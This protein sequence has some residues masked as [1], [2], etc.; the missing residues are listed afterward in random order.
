MADSMRPV[1]TRWIEKLRLARE[2]KKKEF[3][4]D[5]DEA[6]RFFDGPYDWLYKGWR[7]GG[8]GG[9]LAMGVGD[10]DVPGPSVEM[11]V[12]K[13]AE[14]VQLF[15]PA[16]YHQNPY[17][18]VSPRKPPTLPAELY[19]DPND[20]NLQAY[21]QQLGARQMQA[22]AADRSRAMLLEH[23]L[24]YT[25]DALDLKTQSRWAIDEALIKGMGVLWTMP[26][27][28][29][30][31]GKLAGSFFG[32]VDD[33]FMDPDAET[34]GEAKWVARRCR[35]PIWEVEQ[36]YGLPPGTLRNRGSMESYTQAANISASDGGDGDY[37]RKKGESCDLITY[38]KIWSKMGLGGRLSG[39]PIDAADRY[40]G[41]GN[42]VYLVVCDGCTYPLNVPRDLCDFLC[43]EDQS[44]RA[45]AAQAAGQFVQWETPYW[46][47]DAWPFEPIAF[48]WRPRKLWPMS[49]MKPAMGFL[50]F[51]NWTYSMMA[52][53]IRIACRD[54]IAVAKSAGEELKNSI[55]HGA[56]FTI[57][58]VESIHGSIDQVVKFLSH[59]GFNPEIYKVLEGAIAAFERA[60]GLSELMY[61]L[62][63]RQMRSA[64]E[65][66][67]KSDAINVRPDDMATKVEEAMTNLSRREAFCLRWHLS[68]QQLVGV[69]GTDGAQA[70]DQL[71]T[72]SDPAT[73][74]R[75]LEYRIE[76][77]SIR[78]PNR[79]T[80]AENMRQAT[81]SLSQFFFQYAQATGD[82]APFNALVTDWAKSIDLDAAGYQLQPPPPPPPPG[83]GPPPGPP[84]K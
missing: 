42:F 15:G 79:A 9:A 71:L 81:Q 64:Q 65:A 23:V 74:L 19:G 4:D 53:K 44:V 66:S 41:L 68:G 13:T 50:Q 61:G 30:A 31:G 6:N 54:F 45:Q 58:D 28:P 55:K 48:H 11:T 70:W 67:V 73:I 77:N 33:L 69:L 76:A 7:K 27:N 49:H 72:V 36:Q 38:Y 29:A 10:E 37:L 40:D 39:M 35:H 18:K 80:E 34:I 14:L 1:V 26:T 56:D 22:G 24:N 63:N 5:A 16:L 2:H 59:P 78:K 43:D 3:Q 8:P 57:I 82:V 83:Q 60:T 21:L 47:D 17:R 32:T 12:N 20:P 46:A 51:I 62:S 52:A 25:P 84:K 75:S